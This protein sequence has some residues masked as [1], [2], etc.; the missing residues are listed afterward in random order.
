MTVICFLVGMSVVLLTLFFCLPLFNSGFS[1]SV[2]A[3]EGGENAAYIALLAFMLVLF[4]LVCLFIAVAVNV[5]MG[6]ALRPLGMMMGFLKRIGETGNLT[7]AEEEWR[8]VRAAAAR[9]DEIGQSLAALIK[10]LE[11]LAYCDRMLRTVSAR[12]LTA[13]IKTLSDEDTIGRALRAMVENFNEMLK[14]IHL[15][16]DQVSHGSQQIA[17]GAQNLAQGATEQADSVEQLSDSVAEVYGSVVEVTAAAKNLAA[18]AESIRAK[19]E[20]GT[21]QMNE[22]M[23]AVREI[24]EAS[25]NISSVIKI[26]D[27]IAFQ[28][29]ILALNA[30]VEAARA[31]Q[32]GKGF[33]VVAEEVRNLAAKSAEAAKNTGSLIE[34]SVNK[35]EL[36]V[37]IA[38]RTNDSLEEI[39][40]GVVTSS[41]IIDKI[42]SDTSRQSAVV[43]QIDANIGKI[44]QVVQMNTATAEESAAASEELSGQSELLNNLIGRFAIKDLPAALPLRA[45]SPAPP[46][47]GRIAA[48][49]PQG[50]RPASAVSQGAAALSGPAPAPGRRS[51]RIAWSADLETGNELID[52]QHKQLIEALGNLMD[53]CS[54]GKG[55]A[56]LAETMDF[57]EQYTA[58]HFGDEEALQKQYKYP[59]YANHKKLH[60]DFK[61]VVADLGRQ[62]KAE[63]PTVALVGKVNANVGGWLVNHI[64]KEDKKVA[65]HLHSLD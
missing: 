54:G 23:D 40:D 16:A 15:S 24:N 56:A 19:A 53:A 9:K 37:K 60:D 30:A 13:E 41:K 57:L 21:D 61:R 8:N 27:D 45:Q 47:Y 51:E 17:D 25:H 34:N 55:R 14:E 29:N 49:P 28:T 31:G 22:M 48:R 39:V 42:A 11:H 32:Y 36:G 62:L 3:S 35:A 46:A 52:S 38:G 63:G 12:D 44:T 4:A 33:A 6:R 1:V 20:Q 2:A 59:D 64:K 43:E 7:L 10:V 18:H 50:E 58:K 5:A 65:A 26:I